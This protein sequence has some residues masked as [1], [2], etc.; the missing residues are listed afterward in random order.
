MMTGF[1]IGAFLLA[2]VPL[3]WV[4]ATTL[5]NGLNRF[6][7][8]SSTTRCATSTARAAAR[9]TPS[10]APADDHRF[11]DRDLG[12]DRPAHGD[13][14]R[15]STAAATLA[16]GITFFVDVMTGIPS[17]VAGLFA[18]ALMTLLFGPAPSAASRAPS[19]CRC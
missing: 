5:A 10:T 13:L 1:I 18:Y 14:P 3:V 16:R 6:D 15:P 17:I 2:L 11:R 4:A 9:S 19:R 12:A 7:C 8:R